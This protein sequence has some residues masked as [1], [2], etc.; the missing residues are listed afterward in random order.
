[1][2]CEV[3]QVYRETL[4]QATLERSLLRSSMREHVHV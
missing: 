4:E 2:A 3:M 1:V